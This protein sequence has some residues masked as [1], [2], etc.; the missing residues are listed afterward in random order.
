MKNLIRCPDPLRFSTIDT[1][2][3][4]INGYDQI[5]VMEGGAKRVGTIICRTL[6]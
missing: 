1:I 4:K 6:G 2:V 5:L 3:L